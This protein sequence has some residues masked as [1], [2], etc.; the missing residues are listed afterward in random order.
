MDVPE[1]ERQI[2]TDTTNSDATLMTMASDVSKFDITVFPNASA[3]NLVSKKTKLTKMDAPNPPLRPLQQIPT[4]IPDDDEQYPDAQPI[5]VGPHEYMHP[6]LKHRLLRLLATA[7]AIV[8]A[9]LLLIGMC[10]N[11]T[12]Y[13]EWSSG[14]G[15]EAIVVELKCNWTHLRS[16]D[17]ISDPSFGGAFTCLIFMVFAFIFIIIGI[18][19]A[20][21]FKIMHRKCA[22]TYLPRI[23]FIVASIFI[24]ISI[25]AFFT[26]DSVCLTNDTLINSYNPPIEFKLGA[27]I[28]C[29]IIALVAILPCCALAL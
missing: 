25:I 21:P 23:L 1:H 19:Y 12:A 27:S 5:I 24:L 28:I 20:Q 16:N 4:Q 6:P 15:S 22:V 2:S 3:L 8:T 29:D 11:A 7:L 10:A 26:G 14:T 17:N 9:L 13:G 18:L